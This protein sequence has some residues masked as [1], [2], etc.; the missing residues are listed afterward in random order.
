MPSKQPQLLLHKNQLNSAKIRG[1]ILHILK[2]QRISPYP[3]KQQHKHAHRAV[4]R[5]LTAQ[6]LP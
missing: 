3:Q 6:S 4:G 5:T 2:Y 1:F